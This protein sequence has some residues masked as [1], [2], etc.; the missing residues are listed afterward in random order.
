MAS[1]DHDHHEIIPL[2]A[3]DGAMADSEVDS[4]GLFTSTPDLSYFKL[5]VNELKELMELRG[6]EA[7]QQIRDKYGGIHN[8]CRQLYTSENEGNVMV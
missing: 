8:I 2:D 5:D 1:G 6:L 3:V 7:V 4:A